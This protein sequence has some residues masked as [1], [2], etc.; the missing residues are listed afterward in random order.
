[1]ESFNPEDSICFSCISS[2]G[3][4]QV[5]LLLSAIV[6]FFTSVASVSSTHFNAGMFYFLKE[7]ICHETSLDQTHSC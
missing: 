5:L 7:G 6:N 1:M 2:G 4:A 3:L